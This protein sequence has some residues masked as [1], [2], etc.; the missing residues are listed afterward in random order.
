M[1]ITDTQGRFDQ[2]VEEMWRWRRDMSN[3]ATSQG[4]QKVAGPPFAWR[5]EI[6]NSWIHTMISVEARNRDG[7]IQ[8]RPVFL[9]NECF[10]FN[11]VSFSEELKLSWSWF[12]FAPLDYVDNQADL[13]VSAQS[14]NIW[15]SQRSSCL[16][17]G[18]TFL[19][20]AIRCQFP[21]CWSTSL[22]ACTLTFVFFSEHTSVGD[23]THSSLSS[24]QSSSRKDPTVLLC[25]LQPI[26]LCEVPPQKFNYTFAF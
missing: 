9:R 5:D 13:L 15:H 8:E 19:C 12:Q 25:A 21:G 11:L 24:C 1:H 4:S 6:R 17:E 14:V 16:V 22:I 23:S 10:P 26:P 3:V 2:Q 18:Q 20:P 7:V